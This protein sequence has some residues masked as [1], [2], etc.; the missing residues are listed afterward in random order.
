MKQTGIVFE[1]N[2]DKAKII[3]T[4]LAA[5]GS[6]CES[7]S[8]HCG[9]NKQ[10]Y[11]NVK[12]DIGLKIGDRVEI[13]TDSTAVLKYIALVYGLPLI[14]LI[15]GVLIGMLLNLKEMYSL[16]VGFVFM[17]VSFI[18]IKTIDNKNGSNH[19]III[20]KL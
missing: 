3:V 7:C 13:T 10:E 19:G 18:F 1:L 15:S 20:K 4:R 14:F 16:L 5:C 17:I 12:N 11:I 9:E 6:S 2:D 8:A